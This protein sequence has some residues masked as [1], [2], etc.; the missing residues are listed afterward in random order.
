MKN[1]KKAGIV[2][3][4]LKPARPQLSKQHRE[5]LK[6]LKLKLKNNV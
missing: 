2:K 6:S 1:Q 4:T 5:F 3:Q